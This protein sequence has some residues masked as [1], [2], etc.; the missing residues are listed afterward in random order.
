MTLV[1]SD[2]RKAAFIRE[3]A[4]A[5]NIHVKVCVTRV[6]TFEETGFDVAS[7]RALAP[8]TTLFG[9]A[10]PLLSPGGLCL[11]PK[12]RNASAEVDEARRSWHFTIDRYPSVT[13]EDSAILAVRDLTRV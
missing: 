9:Y 1:E 7:A 4:R 5:M 11:F 13:N 8:L 10:A 2:A 12:G 3:A 6:E